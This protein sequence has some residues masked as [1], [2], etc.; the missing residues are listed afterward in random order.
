MTPIMEKIDK[1]TQRFNYRAA[2]RIGFFLFLGWGSLTGRS[3]DTQETMSAR[4]QMF[5]PCNIN[6]EYRD[7]LEKIDFLRIHRVYDELV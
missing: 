6:T 1:H 7:L 2:E 5:P 3:G 4:M